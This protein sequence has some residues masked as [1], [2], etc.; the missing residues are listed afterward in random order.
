MDNARP[1]TD[2]TILVVEDDPDMRA[3]L[4]AFLLREGYLV[5]EEAR[6]DRAG[7]LVESVRLDAAIVDKEIPGM[8]GLELLSL[9]RLRR[10]EVPIILITAF[11]GPTVAEEALRRGA[12]YYVEKPFRVTQIL[13]AVERL[14]NRPKTPS[15]HPDVRP[16]PPPGASEL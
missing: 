2:L 9:F 8:N 3:I 1:V 15:W 6:G 10:P 12:R 13:A 7:L 16:D 14:V 5:L 11:G 4:K